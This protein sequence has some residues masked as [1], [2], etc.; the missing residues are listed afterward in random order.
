[1]L[2]YTFIFIGKSGGG[3]GTQAEM[4]A[5]YLKDHKPQNSVFRLETGARF[6]EYIKGQGYSA[7]LSR[8]IYMS[9]RLQPEFLSTYMWACE[10][11]EKLQPGQHIL[12]DG[13][14]RRL[15]EAIALETALNFYGRL[16]KHIGWKPHDNE[17][18]DKT[19]DKGMPDKPYVVYLDVSDEEVIRR[20]HERG[21]IDDNP[22]D[23]ALR[24]KW[25][26]SDVMPSVRYYRG[27]P[28]KYHFLH[29]NAEQSSE[30]VHRDLIQKVFGMSQVAHKS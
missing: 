26:E 8:D 15:P 20:M 18:V 17:P 3:K 21:R 29:I 11:L 12:I 19:A 1:M 24:L 28:E 10:F 13:S 30:A 7:G 22:K 16:P 25:F 6:R 9:G 5:N 4:V 23:I 27:A 14:P 2:P